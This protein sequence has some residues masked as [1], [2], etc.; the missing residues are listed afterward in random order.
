MLQHAR[1]VFEFTTAANL[2]RI[3]PQRAAS[4]QELYEQLQQV[5]EASVFHHT[6]QSLQA[7]HYLTE[8]F[9][10]DFAQWT[11][12]A[13]NEFALAEQLAAVDV[14]DYLSVADL[15]AR[16]IEVL[17]DYIAANP[18]AGERQAFEP[19][20]FLET[21]TVELPT[22]RTARTL[23]EFVTGLQT[24]SVSSVHFHFLTSRL[25][26]QLASNDF[27]LWLRTSLD[28]PELAE[29]IKRIDVYASTLEGVRLKI[30]EFAQPWLNAE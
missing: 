29:K 3:C 18:G 8:G 4:L 14:R 9:T 23:P 12:A 5:S 20:H 25:R 28:L 21:L 22:G 19:F 11:L 2:T 16:L 17:G 7:H 24:I 26:L 30:I 1:E 15:R 6:F 13:C 10:S 27:S